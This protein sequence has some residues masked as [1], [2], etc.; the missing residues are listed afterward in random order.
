M[1]SRDLV[2]AAIAH[3]HT[4]RVPYCIG[5]TP[6]GK[7][8]LQRLIGEDRDADEFTDNDVLRVGPP[9]WNWHELA[10]D[11]RQMPT[12]TTPANVIGRGSYEQFFDDL[13]RLRDQTG[14]YLLVMVYG[15]HFEKANAARGIENFLA[16][17]AA[18]PPF[19]RRLLRRIIDKNMVMLDNLLTAPEIDGVLLGSDWGTQLDLI[20]SPDTWQDMI[21]PG[22]QEEYDLIHS[23]DK[24]VWIHSC[25]NVEKIIPSLIEMG[26]QVLNP[27]QPEA[28]DLHR[29]KNDFGDKLTFWG[30]VSTQQTLPY[31]TPEEVKVES[32]RV[33]DLLAEDGGLIFSPAQEIQGDVPAENI[34][35]L[36]E[37]ARET[38]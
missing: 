8:E 38:R 15:S 11:W 22:E 4:D 27:I 17:M 29:L 37:V 6:D 26:V 13:K 5:Y 30:G 3:R 9:W 25:G 24:D 10:P 21:R 16:D 33:R 1:D 31:G 7:K 35:A 36:I 32:R 12:P 23:F 18:D 20:M 14:K 19:T 34:I 2:K 28:M